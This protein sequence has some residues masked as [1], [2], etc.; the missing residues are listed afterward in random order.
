MHAVTLLPG[1]LVLIAQIDY[2]VR[3]SAAD[4]ENSELFGLGFSLGYRHSTTTHAMRNC[5]NYVT[6]KVHS[7]CN[8]SGFKFPLRGQARVI[9]EFND[10][11]LELVLVT[12][13]FRL[14]LFQR[15]EPLWTG[16]H[17]G[18]Y[19]RIAVT[20][21]NRNGTDLQSSRF[22]TRIDCVYP[23]LRTS[24]DCKRTCIQ[25][26]RPAIERNRSGL[27]ATEKPMI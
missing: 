13:Q 21:C 2:L 11:R 12:E 10:Q 6:R 26:L 8:V 5:G 15:R 24:I 25:P 3:I 23:A 4:P 9:S 22:S 1:L 14:N 18:G 20:T 27:N 7:V 16:I 17:V 19:D